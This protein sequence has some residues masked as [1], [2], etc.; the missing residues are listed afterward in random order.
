MNPS[1][2]FALLGILDTVKEKLL[3]VSVVWILVKFLIIVL[4]AAV[5]YNTSGGSKGLTILT[6]VVCYILLF[7]GGMLIGL[8]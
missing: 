7:Q 1:D 3:G 6:L 8:R 4:I 2:T 5:V